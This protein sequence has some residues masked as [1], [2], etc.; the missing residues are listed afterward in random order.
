MKH[1]MVVDLT[2]ELANGCGFSFGIFPASFREEYPNPG[3]EDPLSCLFS[4]AAQPR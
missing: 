4:M 3:P 2:V 1:I